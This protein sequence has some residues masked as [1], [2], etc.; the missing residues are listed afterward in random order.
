MAFGILCAALIG[1]ALG[2]DR[3]LRRLQVGW[4]AC[5]LWSTIGAIVA[6]ELRSTEIADNRYAWPLVAA[7][8]IVAVCQYLVTTTPIGGWA[9]PREPWTAVAAALAFGFAFGYGG[10]LL[11]GGLALVVIYALAWRPLVDDPTVTAAADASGDTLRFPGGAGAIGRRAEEG[12]HDD[13]RRQQREEQRE[14]EQFAHAGGAGVAG[15]A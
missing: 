9:R 8:T 4:G 12:R 11:V 14:S 5:A 10:H 1:A 2:L 13:E 15:Q 7:A 6:A 3:S